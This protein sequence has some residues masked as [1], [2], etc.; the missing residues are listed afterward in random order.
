MCGDWGS[1]FAWGVGVGMS[2]CDGMCGGGVF[3]RGGDGAS[4]CVVVYWW[5]C[6]FAWGCSG[7]G[8]FVREGW[9]GGVVG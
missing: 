2:V 8:V 4:F 5:G 6:L 9:R 7:E 3:S 1:R